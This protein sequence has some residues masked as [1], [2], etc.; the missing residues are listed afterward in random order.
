MSPLMNVYLLSFSMPCKFAGLAPTPILSIFINSQS[1]C[2]VSRCL[3]KLLPMKPKP[4]VTRSFMC[5]SL[6]RWVVPVPWLS[7]VGI[8]FFAVYG[9]GN[10]FL[11]VPCSAFFI[12]FSI[13]VMFGCEVKQHGWFMAY[14]FVTM[15]IVP[16]H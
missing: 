5:F 13:I 7:D 9:F 2:F 4:P 8:V 3:Q 1:G 11:V 6:V 12:W 14:Y 15:P 10:Y 16:G